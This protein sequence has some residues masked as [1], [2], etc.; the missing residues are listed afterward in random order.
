MHCR[1]FETSQSPSFHESVEGYHSNSTCY[2]LPP[3]VV[4]SRKQFSSLT[5]NEHAPFSS[6]FFFF[7]FFL[8]QLHSLHSAQKTQLP[9]QVHPQ[10]THFT[11]PL[12]LFPFHS[13]CTMLLSQGLIIFPLLINLGAGQ[14]CPFLRTEFPQRSPTE[15]LKL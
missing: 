1:N 6:T 4:C 15:R 3:H 11:P 13:T 12:L 5:R 7:F 2:L 10:S 9:L 8:S 14:K